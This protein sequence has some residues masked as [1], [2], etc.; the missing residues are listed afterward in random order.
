MP[1]ELIDISRTQTLLRWAEID[2]VFFFLFFITRVQSPLLEGR[3]RGT[4]QGGQYF[5]TLVDICRRSLHDTVL[6]NTITM[7]ISNTQLYTS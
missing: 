5:T 2:G 6:Y 4:E 7:L 3:N 1:A